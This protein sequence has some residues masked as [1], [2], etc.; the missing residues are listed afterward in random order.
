MLMKLLESSCKT[1]CKRIVPLLFI[2]VL[3]EIHEGISCL[4]I[5]PSDR[6]VVCGGGRGGVYSWDSSTGRDANF[7]DGGHTGPVAVVQCCTTAQGEEVVVSCGASDQT[8][9]VS[10]VFGGARHGVV[11]DGESVV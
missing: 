7:F 10:D 2:Q 5:S 6:V 3:G 4:S 1:S 8:I 9:V 11:G